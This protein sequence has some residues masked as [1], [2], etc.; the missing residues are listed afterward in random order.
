MIDGD[1]A[2]VRKEQPSL[3]VCGSGV[4]RS[5]ARAPG[6]VSAESRKQ[7][8]TGAYIVKEVVR[9]QPVGMVEGIQVAADLQLSKVV[10]TGDAA[11]LFLGFAQPRQQQRR[12]DCN[13]GNHH[14]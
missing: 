14:Q 9:R 10:Q 13:N 5:E 7:R 6:D 1:G 12:Q 2:V 3:D 8:C 11:G 4:I